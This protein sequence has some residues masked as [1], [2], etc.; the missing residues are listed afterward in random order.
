MFRN[1]GFIE[2][3]LY[4]SELPIKSYGFLKVKNAFWK[5]KQKRKRGF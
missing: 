4:F 1:Y 2:L 5:L 3:V